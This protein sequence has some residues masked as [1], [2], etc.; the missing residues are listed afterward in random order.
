MLV[1]LNAW[2]E[3]STPERVKNV[4]RIVRLNVAHSNDRFQTRSM[5]R[6]CWTR[7]E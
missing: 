4:P 3:L 1:L 6:R 2:T 7:I 5:P